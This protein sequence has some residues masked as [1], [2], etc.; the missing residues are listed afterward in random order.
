MCALLRPRLEITPPALQVLC[1][2]HDVEFSVDICTARADLLRITVEQL[3]DSSQ[4]HGVFSGKR[5]ARSERIRHRHTAPLRREDPCCSCLY[6]AEQASIK[7]SPGYADLEEIAAK[8]GSFKSYEV[9]TKMLL[10]ALRQ[11]SEHV[12]AD[13][14]TYKDLDM[15]QQRY[16]AQPE[17]AR[18]QPVS[19]NSKRYLILTYISEFDRVHYPLPLQYVA[20]PDPEYLKGI[21]ERLRSEAKQQVHRAKRGAR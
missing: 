19:A 16:P 1:N 18:T 15:L 20:A 21:I 5:T 12:V 17:A 10:K 13:L 7:L 14:L 4:W 6:Q 9:F 8:T 2:F 3:T 11:E